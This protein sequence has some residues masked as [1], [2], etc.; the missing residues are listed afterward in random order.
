MGVLVQ[1]LG[2]A[3]GSHGL[4]TVQGPHP[5][6]HGQNELGNHDPAGPPANPVEGRRQSL[7]HELEHR[8]DPHLPCPRQTA[9]SRRHPGGQLGEELRIRGGRAH[10]RQMAGTCAVEGHE[11]IGLAAT[12]VTTRHKHV[13]TFPLVAMRGSEGIKIHA[14]SLSW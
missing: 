9:A 2:A 12:E 3:Q 13:E 10:P 6:H 5:H 4:G 14:R 8:A 11:L 7:Q 1:L